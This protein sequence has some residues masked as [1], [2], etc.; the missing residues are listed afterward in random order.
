MGIKIL[1]YLIILPISILP[2]PLL[3]FV[4]D[5]SYYLIY[6]MV[7]YRKNVVLTNIQKSFPEKSNKE[8]RQIMD[9][10]Y[11]HFSDLV[12]ESLK[13]FSVSE[14]QIR[15]RFVL[16]NPELMDELY[17]EGRDVVLVGGH[18]NNWEIL[19]LGINYELKHQI[20]GIYKPIT[21]EF[22][23][24]KMKTSREKY[25]LIMVPTYDTRDTFK[26]SFGKQNAIIF[27]VDQ[28]PSHPEN[29]H[30]MTF[31]NQDT[32]VVFGAEKYAKE[33]DRPVVHCSIHKAK[34]GHYEGELSLIT[35]NP[36]DLP[37]GAIIEMSTKRI[38]QDIINKPE[39]WLWTHR[40]WKAKRVEE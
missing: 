35:K 40:R 26:R 39:Y 32:A 7:G 33:Y 36:N 13:G 37:H 4:A 10:F 16:R 38:E 28:S 21:N 5:I 1:Y 27:G 23:N 11:R 25:G 17:E 31:L 24:A 19:A 14:K 18:Y 34:R 8:H 6:R 9:K 3:Y 15:K 20:I 2:Y 29:S 22:L 30:W 12:F